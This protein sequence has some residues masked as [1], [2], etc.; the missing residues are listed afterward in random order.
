MFNIQLLV[1]DIL[2][3]CFFGVF[4]TIY[5]FQFFTT[6]YFK[7]SR[8]FV[9]SHAIE[10]YRKRERINEQRAEIAESNGDNKRERSFFLP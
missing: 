7:N 3:I 9:Y 10:D 5:N 6:N 1:F 4:Q 8:S 2:I